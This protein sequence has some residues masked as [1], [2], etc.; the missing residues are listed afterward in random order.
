MKGFIEVT[1]C[2]PAWFSDEEEWTRKRLI[3]INFLR[4]VIPTERIA[5][6]QGNAISYPSASIQVI[7]VPNA[8]DRGADAVLMV[9]E[10]YEEVKKLIEGAIA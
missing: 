2:R 9:T 6:P 1:Q 8:D 10:T 3:N 4:D 5:G 7:D